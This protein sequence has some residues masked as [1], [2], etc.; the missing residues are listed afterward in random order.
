VKAEA[1][2]LKLKES[3]RSDKEEVK[4]RTSKSAGQDICDEKEIKSSSSKSVDQDKAYREE[5]MPNCIKATKEGKTGKEKV[6]PSNLKSDDKIDKEEVSSNSND[7]CKAV[8]KRE[9]NYKDVSGKLFTVTWRSINPDEDVEIR[10][11]ELLPTFNRLI[12]TLTIFT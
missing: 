3:E 4:S 11:E 2:S 6:K 1:R 12:L 5:V 7:N 8:K 10:L 9:C